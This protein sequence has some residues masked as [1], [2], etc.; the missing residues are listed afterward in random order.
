LSELGGQTLSSKARVDAFLPDVSESAQQSRL[1]YWETTA[2][3]LASIPRSELSRDAATD[4]AVYADQLATLIAQQQQRMFEWPANADT[5]FWGLLAGRSTRSL[6]SEDDA[7][8]YLAQLSDIPRYFT[9]QMA[10]MTAGVARGFGP[11]RISMEGRDATIRSVIESATPTDVCF[12]APFMTLPGTVPKEVQD[13][14]RDEAVALISGQLIPAYEALLVFITDSYFP[15]LP[16]VIGASQ[17]PNGAAFYEAQLREFTTTSLTPQ[18]IFDHGMA[19]VESLQAEMSEIAEE[20][21]YPNDVPGLLDF[22]KTDPQFYVSTPEELLRE[23]AWQAK[24][25]DSR[26]HQYFGRTPRMR[27]GIIEPPAD[28]APFYTAG[29]GGLDRYT[30]NTYNLP[31]R[32]LYSLPSLTLH[33]AAPGHAFQTPFALEQTQHPSFRREVYISAY[34]EGWAL[35]CER[36]GVEMGMYDTPYEVMGMLSYQMWRAVRLVIDPGMHAFGWSRER[37]QDFLRTNTAISEHEIVTEVDRYIAWPGQATAYF[38]GEMAIIKLRS[39]A[40]IALGAD[41]DL[42]NFHDAVLA[43]GSVPLSVVEEAIDWFIETGGAS[44]FSA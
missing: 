5:S 32:P 15:R 14:L 40:E 8:R 28:L 35:Y 23:A 13:A 39:K 31:A 24:K 7:R 42:R 36:L 12:Y 16:T 10:N 18:E 38:I 19:A 9:Q 26:V 30:L 37:A 33:E 3:T 44:P 29:R 20:T 1:S 11:P 21:G 2:A 34:G 17:L 25:F 41:F 43:L 22:M 6:N 27:F 4:Q